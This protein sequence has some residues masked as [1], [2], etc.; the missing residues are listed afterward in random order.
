[1]IEELNF[2]TFQK[3]K[4]SKTK[5]HTCHNGRPGI[6]IDTFINFSQQQKITTKYHLTSLE[7][8]N[9]DKSFDQI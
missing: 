3:K 4:V 5:T 6:L 8:F 7:L 1:M 9:V 2:T